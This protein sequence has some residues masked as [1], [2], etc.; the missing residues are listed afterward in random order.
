MTTIAW[1]G[2]TL[3][4]DSQASTDGIRSRVTKIAK[5]PSGFIAAG[6][7]SFNAILPWLRWITGGLKE[8]EQPTTLRD[9]SLI[10]VDPRGRAFIF[11]NQPLRVPL[12][13]KYWA[14][15]SGANLAMG[16]MGAGADAKRAVQVAR[17]HDVYT[18]GR[19]VTA[20][21]GPRR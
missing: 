12:R 10:V 3:A 1:D 21:P 20:V 7:G 16:A 9:S 8:D 19:I 4:A 17:R 6:S 15:G 13:E 5:S 18:G 14:I 11:E 2:K